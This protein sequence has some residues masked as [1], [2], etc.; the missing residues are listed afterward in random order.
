M[1]GQTMILI[2]GG[3]GFIGLNTAVRLLEAGEQVVITQ[4]TSRRI[5]D[6]LIVH[7]RSL[8]QSSFAARLARAELSDST[9]R[10]PNVPATPAGDLSRVKA[11][12]G[13]EPE[14]T[15]PLG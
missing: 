1:E 7:L 2:I 5:P 9:A 3:M 4:H 11:D 14:H 10:T 8:P 15:R 13:Y 6:L 12:V